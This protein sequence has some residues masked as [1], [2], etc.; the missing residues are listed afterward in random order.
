MQGIDL[1]SQQHRLVHQILTLAH[2]R[3]AT[4]GDE[5]FPHLAPLLSCAADHVP[6]ED[7]HDSGEHPV[8]Q[9]VA[10]AAAQLAARAGIRGRLSAQ[11]LDACLEELDRLPRT[12]R[13]ALL[14]AAVRHTVPEQ[15][16]PPAARTPTPVGWS[17]VRRR[18]GGG[19]LCACNS[20]GFCGG[21]G[22][23][24]CGGRR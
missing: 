14:A 10:E 21:C 18:M 1:P 9:A 6:T 20:G 19:C 22:H 24:G 15:P 13:V 16:H 3:L 2:A 11:H 17:P 8:A 12:A 7:L 5:E 23:S 4:A